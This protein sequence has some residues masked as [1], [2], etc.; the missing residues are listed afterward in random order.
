M[1]SSYILWIPLILIVIW[2]L[3]VRPQ[4]AARARALE[5]ENL[6][7][8]G[9]EVITIGG[10]YGTIVSIDDLSVEL[11]VSDGVALRVARRAIAGRAPVDEP[12]DE[13]ED[14]DDLE[15]DDELLEED[16]LEDDGE[17]G[18]GIAVPGNIEQGGASNQQPVIEP[19]Q[20]A[21]ESPGR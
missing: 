4:R 5:L 13:L 12:E 15:D 1:D 19:A 7:E 17:L 9:Q 20:N 21:D 16:D 3:F 6:L 18:R 10:L 11:D 14:D 2:F 8:V